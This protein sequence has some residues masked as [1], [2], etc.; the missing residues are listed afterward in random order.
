VSDIDGDGDLDLLAANDYGGNSVNVRLNPGTG[1]FISGPNVLVGNL[2]VSIAMGD[3]NGDG[4]VDLLTAN[5]NSN[6]VSVRLNGGI[7]PPLATAASQTPAALALFPNP[8]HGA[9]N[10][11]GATPH[12]PVMVLD[13]LGRVRLTATTDAAGAAQLLEGLPAGVYLVRSGQQVRR[14]VVE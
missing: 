13:A 7:G 1:V 11:T 3:V 14:L 8:A 5:I 12:A 9:A 2:P 10:L 4:A 6:N